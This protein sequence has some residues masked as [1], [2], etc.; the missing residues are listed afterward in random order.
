MTDDY[1]FLPH[2]GYRSVADGEQVANDVMRQLVGY[3]AL[4]K[5]DCAPLTNL[6][7]TRDGLI[8]DSRYFAMLLPEEV[9]IPDCEASTHM[10]LCGR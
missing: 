6:K 5:Y 8:R 4:D 9:K 2:N 10:F 3:I 7:I 1:R